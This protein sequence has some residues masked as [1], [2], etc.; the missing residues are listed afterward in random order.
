MDGNPKVI[1]NKIT[2]ESVFDEP[3]GFSEER[4]L[5]I[6]RLYNDVQDLF[7]DGYFN[8]DEIVKDIF[9]NLVELGDN[10][11]IVCADSVQTGLIV[12]DNIEFSG[13]Y[14]HSCILHLMFLKNNGSG[15]IALK[16]GLRMVEHLFG[17][18]FK[19]IT[20]FIDVEN[21]AGL[22]LYQ[23]MGFEIEGLHRARTRLKGEYRDEYSLAII[24]PE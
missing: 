5:F 24:N 13:D 3:N 6:G 19:R 11:W 20:T 1:P 8:P 16:S 2:F 18:G 22:K 10:A 14:W 12:V 7:H 23:R 4:A 15:K 21:Q 17:L 9:D